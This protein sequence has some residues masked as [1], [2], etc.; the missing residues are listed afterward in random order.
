MEHYCTISVG[1]KLLKVSRPTVYKLIEDGKL[2]RYKQMGRPA[3]KR[4]EVNKLAKRRNG[5]GI[6]KSG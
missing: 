3:L 6:K 4:S 5:N 1:A 2:G